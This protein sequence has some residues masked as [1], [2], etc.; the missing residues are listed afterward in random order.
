MLLAAAAVLVA[1]LVL[2]LAGN[3]ARADDDAE[4]RVRGT[5]SRTSE[6]SLRARADDGRIRIDVRIDTRR[7]GAAW[8]VIVLHE[9]RIAY[10]GV[11]RTNRSRAIRLRRTVRDLFGRDSLVV[12]ASGP[13]RETCRVSG[14]L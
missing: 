4:I 7:R 9:R 14:S 1:A 13:A 8:S 12:R 2:P 10:R 5:C 11:V 3:A 6:A